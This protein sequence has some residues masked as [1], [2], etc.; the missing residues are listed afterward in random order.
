MNVVLQRDVLLSNPLA[1]SNSSFS[2]SST[3]KSMRMSRVELIGR[4]FV[5]SSMLL[6]PPSSWWQ[7][8]HEATIFYKHLASL[9]SAKNTLWFLVGFDVALG[10]LSL[11]CCSVHLRYT[12]IYWCGFT[13]N[14]FSTSGALLSWSVT[15]RQCYSFEWLPLCNGIIRIFIMATF[16]ITE[17][18]L[19]LYHCVMCWT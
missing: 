16:L 17:I 3:F 6:L 14:E 19:D 9:L 1:P 13:T 18:V 15:F 12:L 5:R 7:L 4:E 8:A 2:L 11:V 10:F